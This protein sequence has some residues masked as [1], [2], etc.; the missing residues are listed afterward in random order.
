MIGLCQEDRWRSDP[1]KPSSLLY[2]KTPKQHYKLEGVM[3]TAAP[4]A[5]E[6]ELSSRTPLSI[7]RW[8]YHENFCA[9]P[10]NRTQEYLGQHPKFG[11]FGSIN[12]AGRVGPR[13][14]HFCPRIFRWMIHVFSF[15]NNL[16]D[17]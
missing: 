12:T 13:T 3:F 7:V 11:M 17:A 4:N 8:H 6:D 5:S 10:A 15:E 9:A 2:F 16:K 1:A 14:E